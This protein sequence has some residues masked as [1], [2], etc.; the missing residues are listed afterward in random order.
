MRLNNQFSE[1]WGDCDMHSEDKR[2]FE[3]FEL[4]LPLNYSRID[5]GGKNCIHT[6]DIS[7]AGMGVTSDNALVPGTVLNMSLRVPSLDK[8]LSSQGK[9]IWSKRL[10]NSFRAGISLNRTEL[11]E[12]STVLRFLHTRPA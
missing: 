9:V 12:I 2:I 8:E 3:R 10:G 1:K 4:E 7:A 6:H 11:M 5:Y